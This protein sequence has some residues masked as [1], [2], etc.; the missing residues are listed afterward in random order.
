MV[1]SKNSIG[2]FKL[3]VSVALFSF[4]GLPSAC[5]RAYRKPC[6]QT[7]V[8]EGAVLPHVKLENAAKRTNLP[9]PKPFPWVTMGEDR[10]A[11]QWIF[12]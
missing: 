6:G 7:P 5:G 3:H 9:N 8:M 11:P 12:S 1:A 10:V 4:L 2:G